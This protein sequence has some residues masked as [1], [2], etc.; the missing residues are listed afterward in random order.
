MIVLAYPWSGV[1]CPGELGAEGG[2]GHEADGGEDADGGQDELTQPQPHHGPQR[3]LEGGE[4]RDPGP[5][6]QP[7]VPERGAG[8]GVSGHRELTVNIMSN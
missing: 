5:G 4:G 6:Q 8:G 1:E 2:G 3:G 7:R